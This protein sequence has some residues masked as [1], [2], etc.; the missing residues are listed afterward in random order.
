MSEPETAVAVQTP[1][2]PL[3]VGHVRGGL[4]P[5]SLD[6]LW[7]FS[8]LLH[9]SGMM[10]KGLDSVEAVAAAVQM[11]LE[12]GLTPMQAVQSIA[13]INGRPSIWGDAALG[14]VRAS[15]M[16]EDFEETPIEDKGEIVGFRCR[17]KR[18]GQD[19]PIERVF[20]LT[21]AKRANLM[22]K[23]GPWKQYP[24]RML[25]MRARSW[26]LRDGFSD[27]LRGLRL[28]EEQVDVIPTEAIV[29][30][31]ETL[32]PGRHKL[33]KPKALSE[34]TSETPAPFAE[35]AA[36]F[37]DIKPTPPKEPTPTAL[38]ATPDAA[39]RE[40]DEAMKNAQHPIP[41]PDPPPNCP[42]CETNEAVESGKKA[43]TWHCKT[44]GQIFED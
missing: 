31:T 9:K 22:D 25:Q 30:A 42:K 5:Q 27:V 3:I 18:A 16:L 41:P 35:T 1:K 40:I 39:D 20:T 19:A 4:V 36:V 7:R 13:V 2:A 10:P 34:K 33:P 14:L 23:P 38:D 17:A 24:Q 29:V 32:K 8:V 26:A 12:V 28:S 44:C 11:G 43:F 6:E 21:D 15:G 37:A